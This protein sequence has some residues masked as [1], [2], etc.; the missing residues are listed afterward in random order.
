MTDTIRACLWMLGT[1]MS[2]IT[3]AVCGRLLAGTLDTF[4]I[5]MYRSIVGVIVVC[6]VIQLRGLW[7]EITRRHLGIHLLRNMGHFAG[8]NLW[9]AALALIPLA[10]VFALEF[11]TPLWVLVLSPL[12]LGERLTRIGALS[13]ALGFV[14]IL[15]VTRPGMI[16]VSTGVLLASASAIGF[17]LSI[18]LTRKLTRTETIAC[19]LFYLTTMQLLMGIVTVVWDG[20]IAVPTA[21]EIPWV[22]MIGF[23]GLFAHF[24]YTKALSLAPATIVSPV[25]FI[26]LPLIMIVGAMFFSEAMDPFVALGAILI[27]GANYLNIWHSSRQQ[28]VAAK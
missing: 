28:A 4:E 5:M 21:G 7:P 1:V 20:D 11:T 14:G 3:M 18:L 13:A 9:F 19:I 25:D 24:C 15:I 23:A 8:Q 26:R 17:A 16:E 22:I 10:Q 12:L 6:A 2:F 27:F